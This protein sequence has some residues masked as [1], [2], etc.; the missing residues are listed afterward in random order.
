[1]E[2]DPEQQAFVEAV[3]A[4]FPNEVVAKDQLEQALAVATTYPT[5]EVDDIA[6]ATAR[7][8]STGCGFKT[9]NMLV[10]GFS[11]LIAVATSWAAVAGPPAWKSLHD[12]V[13]ANG[14]ER[15]ISSMCCG[16]RTVPGF[17]PTR[18]Y[19]LGDDRGEDL[20]AK[21]ILAKVTP[22]NGRI[23]FGDVSCLDPVDRWRS[24]W[25][26]HPEDPA[27][28]FAYALVHFK[29]HS[30]WPDDFVETGERLDPGNGWFRL[31]AG[32]MKLKAAVGVS[33]EED[34][35]RRFTKEERMQAGADGRQLKR[36]EKEAK[37]EKE[38]IDQ[39]AWEDGARLL[40]ESLAMPK[41]DDYR[42]S[43]ASLRF[44]AAPEIKDLATHGAASLSVW[45][46]PEIL[47]AQDWLPLRSCS[48]AISIAIRDAG[49]CGDRQRLGELHEL[50]VLLGD[51]LNGSA[52]SLLSHLVAK[53]VITGPN[54]ALAAAWAD[55]GAPE[56]GNEFESVMR[57]LDWKSTPRPKPPVDA[58]DEYRGSGSL[59]QSYLGSKGPG[60]KPVSEAEIRGGRLAEYALYER[61]MLHVAAAL[62]FLSI[63]FLTS[64][65]F[66]SGRKFGA[67][68]SRLAGLL[69][70]Q[71]HAWILAWG[72]LLPMATYI[73][74]T[75]TPWLAPREFAL[76]QDRFFMW[77]IQASTMVALVILWTIQ[78]ACWRLRKRGGVLALGWPG[79]NPGA[80]FALTALTGMIL[81]PRLLAAT[82]DAGSIMWIVLWAILGLIGG[83]PWLWIIVLATGQI[84][85][86]GRK[87]HRSVLT[88]VLLPFAALALALT[89]LSI[90]RI[91]AEEKHWVSKMDFDAFKEQTNMFFPRT[92]LEYADWIG[93]E[94]ER[95]LNE[96][97]LIPRD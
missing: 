65:I 61:L 53:A 71:D 67:L 96:L 49:K 3:I 88:R 24:V 81:G 44:D 33:E 84:A 5:R 77:L 38:I 73:L 72:V 31:L 59:A 57:K 46:R 1:M 45:R 68:P 9:R 28:F 78:A 15:V 8:R 55:L 13:L 2:F 87:L 17:L 18:L 26:E 11:L 43:L 63:I 6:T 23:L 19:E 89:A 86:E 48:E 51:S 58:L 93:L 64:S 91:Y 54:K 36:R 14:M 82:P 80:W 70:W 32:A 30:T 35:G 12:I 16:Y 94:V 90:P 37:Q 92:E 22:E 10:L 39:A 66:R 4:P 79:V 40:R 25:L 56:R 60:S 41:L 85:S 75:R 34:P 29:V 95:G 83:L 69:R 74:A 21:S 50:S 27:H 7:M 52:S 20:Y 47:S 62:L 42:R 97:R 76:S